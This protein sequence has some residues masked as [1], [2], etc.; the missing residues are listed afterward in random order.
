MVDF[1]N[2]R[3]FPGDRQEALKRGDQLSASIAAASILAK[4]ERDTFMSD[5]D[6]HYPGYGFASHKGYGTRGHREAIKE[7]GITKAH[8]L[9]FIPA[10]L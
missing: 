5:L 3:T 2:L 10:H 7:R 4:V 1:F 8:R 6:R 9:S